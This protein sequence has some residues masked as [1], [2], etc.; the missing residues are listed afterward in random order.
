MEDHRKSLLSL[1]RICTKKLGRV[2]YSV[3]APVGKG[4]KES[5][6]S[7]CF[8]E[9]A[10]NPDIHPPRYCNA[11]YLTMKRKWQ[12]R[13]E[14]KVYRSSLAPH[15]WESHED[16]S[17]S[18][19][20]MVASRKIGGRP[21]LPARIVGCP[22]YLTSHVRS[23]AGPKYR[24]SAPLTLDRFP[25]GP[26]VDDLVCPL[27]Q[28]I[29]DE[30][31]ELA[32]KHHL[33]FPCCL[34]ILTSNIT[35]F[36][37]PRC[38]HSHELAVASFQSPAPIVDKLLQQLVVICEAE[39]CTKSVYLRDLKLHIESSCKRHHCDVHHAVTLDQVLQE[40]TDTP[41][42]RIEM[43]TAGHVVRKILAN[44]QGPFSLPTGGHVSNKR[45]LVISQLPLLSREGVYLSNCV[46]VHC[47]V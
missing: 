30:P 12:A 28:N 43:E 8:G 21:K 31:V 32:C 27:C 29:L 23:I 13:K 10:H 17:C 22:A 1:C 33:C 5:L 9:S 44:S 25:S 2:S 42:T 24:C 47:I 45:S 46:K 40:P 26:G 18:T 35:S 34:Q 36:P 19:C 11:C 20:N 4:G 3:D 38:N 15:N 7:Q 39:K 41:P 37:C 14:G 16:S 6:Y